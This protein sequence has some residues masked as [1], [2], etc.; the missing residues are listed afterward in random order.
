MSFEVLLLANDFCLGVDFKTTV[1]IQVLAF[2][3][4]LGTTKSL[5][6]TVSQ[7]SQY[8][9]GVRKYQVFEVMGLED[10]FLIFLVTETDLTSFGSMYSFNCFGD[11]E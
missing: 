8:S 11:T 5:Y 9:T 10:N 2:L 1:T 3:F 4:E 7:V 6:P